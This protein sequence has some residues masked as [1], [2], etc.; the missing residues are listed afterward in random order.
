MLTVDS[1]GRVPITKVARDGDS[2]YLAS[3]TP[4]GVITLTPAVVMPARQAEF[5]ADPAKAGNLKE[6]MI[7]EA[8]LVE[9]DSDLAKALQ[10]AATAEE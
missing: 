8:D 7:G 10:E 6:A 1:R 9:P 2:H 3:S 4:D 5:L